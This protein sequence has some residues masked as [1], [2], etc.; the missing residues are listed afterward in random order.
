MTEV[1]NLSELGN[2]WW[3][4]GAGILPR[5]SRDFHRAIA[6]AVKSFG[7]GKHGLVR[8]AA[9]ASPRALRPAWTRG[10]MPT[11]LNDLETLH[12]VGRLPH[13]ARQQR[14]LFCVDTDLQ[15]PRD[16]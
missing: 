1:E 7:P 5:F 14:L 2:Y 3:V 6:N 4:F 8:L 12:G 16:F 13:L 10:A 11:R 9:W 15:C